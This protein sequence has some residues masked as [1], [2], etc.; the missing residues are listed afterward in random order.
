[1]CNYLGTVVLRYLVGLC[2]VTLELE[3]AQFSSCRGPLFKLDLE[4]EIHPS[5][6]TVL[7]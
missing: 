5:E 3:T 2:A 1:M 6:V 4:S 7:S